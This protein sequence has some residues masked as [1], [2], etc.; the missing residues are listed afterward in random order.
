MSSS[1][2]A[3][4]AAVYRDTLLDDVIPFWSR[5]GVDRRHGGFL[6]AL[7]RDGTLLDTDKSVWFQGRGAWMFATLF[8]DVEPRAEWLEAAAGGIGFLRDHCS[9]PDGKLWFT[10]TRDGR[11]LRGRRYVYSEAFAAMACAAY[12]RAAGDEGAADRA[13]RSFDTFLDHS[14]TE[15][16]SAPKVE[17]ATRPMKGLGPRMFCLHTA[18]VLREHL[19]DVLVRGRSCTQWIDR[20][21]DEIERDF[22]KPDHEALLEVVGPGGEVI[23]HFEGRQLNPGHAIECAWFVMQEGRLRGDDRLVRLG[24]TILD[25]SWVRGWDEE[26]GGIH[27]FRDLH[28]TP[29]QEPCHDMKYWWP[30]CEAIIATLLAWRLTGDARYAAWHRLVHEWSFRHF[31]D[32]EHGE[33]YGYLHRDGSVALRLKGSMW[34]GP[35]HLPRMLLRCWRMLEEPA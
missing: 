20:S 22:L 17:P 13:V 11:P 9:G 25:W 27:S 23:D 15:G 26:H 14:F 31:P 12:A 24:A 2:P 10:V 1:I 5:H 16:R 21:I 35:F 19:G 6:T 32:P 29:V 7:D 4:L 3:D 33:W 18:Q 28:G 8:L 30:H 34:K